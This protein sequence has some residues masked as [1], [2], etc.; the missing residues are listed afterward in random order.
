[1][2]ETRTEY[3]I[4]GT[5][6]RHGKSVVVVE[7]LPGHETDR[8]WNEQVV[9]ERREWQADATLVT[10]TVTVTEWADAR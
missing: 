1:M 6:T 8:D 10:R 2:T 9:E 3:A 7:V 4:K 5:T